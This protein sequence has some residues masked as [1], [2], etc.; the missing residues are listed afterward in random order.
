MGVVLAGLGLAFGGLGV[1]VVSNLLSSRVEPYGWVAVR[2]GFVGRG[3]AARRFGMVAAVVGG[4]GAREV[5]Y[6]KKV[7][8]CGIIPINRRASETR[9]N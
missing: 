4:V 8:K 2:V 1:A 7:R 9:F 3:P 6:L 5:I